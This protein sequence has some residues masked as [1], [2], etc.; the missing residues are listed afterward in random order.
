MVLSGFHQA[1]EYGVGGCGRGLFGSARG[2]LLAV[3]GWYGSLFDGASRAFPSLS[4]VA[5]LAVP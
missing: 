5:L 1:F 2:G 4:C 3:T